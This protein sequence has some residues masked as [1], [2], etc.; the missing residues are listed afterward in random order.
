MIGLTPAP[1]SVRGAL[2]RYYST[3]P[4]AAYVELV[5]FSGHG[6]LLMILIATDATGVGSVKATLDGEG[7]Q[8]VTNAAAL[9][10][11]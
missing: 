8:P 1:A 10:K 2:K 4:G 5:N 11:Y 6:K 3:N 9:K 7:I